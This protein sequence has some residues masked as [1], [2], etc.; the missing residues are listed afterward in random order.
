[1][2][3]PLMG[4]FLVVFFFLFLAGVGEGEKISLIAWPGKGGHIELMPTQAVCP[5]FSHFHLEISQLHKSVL[6]MSFKLS[7]K[8]VKTCIK[9]NSC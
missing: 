5:L 7:W 8:F 4:L 9:F 1:M 2:G 6:V 3:T